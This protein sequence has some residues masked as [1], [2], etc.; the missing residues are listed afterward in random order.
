[1]EIRNSP[2][3]LDLYWIDPKASGSMHRCIL[4]IGTGKTLKIQEFPME[5]I[6][7]LKDFAFRQF[8]LKARN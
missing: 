6:L 1:M 8:T 7:G 5:T 2:I 4:F 3:L